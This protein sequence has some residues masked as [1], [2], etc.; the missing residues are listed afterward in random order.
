MRHTRTFRATPGIL[1]LCCALAACGPRGDAAA[2]DR[3]ASDATDRGGDARL[4]ACALITP[5]DIQ[6][7]SGYAGAVRRDPSSDTSCWMTVD[8]QRLGLSISIGPYVPTP[9]L[10]GRDVEL[11]GGI[12]GRVSDA[13]WLSTIILPDDT[14]IILLIDGTA[15]VYPTGHEDYRI[16]LGDGRQVSL[17]EQYDAYA[18]TILS[19]LP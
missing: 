12:R 11:E 19:R 5:A 8:D 18:K 3:P 4:S 13:G 1:A 9:F 15:L 6:R 7:I 14:A 16:E 2:G 17:N 10:G